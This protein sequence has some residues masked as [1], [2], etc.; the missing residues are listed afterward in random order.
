MT[1][2]LA[3][4]PG[5][6][7]GPYEVTGPI[8]QGGMG[9]V[10]SARDT[11]L[12]R[13]V[14]LKV[15]PADQVADPERRRRFLQ[16]ARAASAL[17]HPNI[18]TL[19][20]IAHEAGVDFLV[21]EH[22]SGTPL[23]EVIRSGKLGVT[24]TIDYATQIASA[25][26]AAHSAGILH[27]DIKPANLIVTS[28][29]RVKVL[30]FGLAK[31]AERP[32]PDGETRTA[33]RALTRPGM[34]MGTVAYMSPEQ[35]RGEPLDGRTDLFS[36]GVVLYE[37]ATGRPAFAKTLDWTRPSATGLPP[38]LQP[39]VFKL[40]EQ[41]VDLRYQTAADVAA[42]LK[43]LQRV[44]HGPE[45]SRR[46]W[47]RV[48]AAAAILAGI[49][50][51]ATWL[52]PDRRPPGRDEWVQLTNFPDSVSQP[53]ISPDGRMLTFIRGPG[54]FQT[55]GQVYVK[56]LPEGEPKQLT[57]DD[58]RKMSPVFSPDG[59]QIAYTTIN[60]QFAWDT[61]LV[62]VLG[63]EP[64][65]WLPNASGLVWVDRQQLLFSEIKAGQ[66]MAIVT[67]E[68][69]RAGARDVYIPAHERGMGHRS[70]S[71]PDRAWVVIVEM[72]G[73]GGWAPC[74]LVPLDGSSPGRQVGPPGGG[75]TFA[76]WSPD[77]ASIYLSSSAG[78]AFHLWRQPF[79]DGA[80]E[81]ITS[82]PTEEEGVALAPDGRSLVTAV[83]LRQRSIMLHAESAE[84]QISLEGYAFNPKFTPDG[85]RLFYQV[86]KSASALP[87]SS[88]LWMADVDSGRSEHF[89]S[90]VASAG[91]SGGVGTGSYSI[92]RDGRRVVLTMADATGKFRL[93]LVTIDRSAPPRQIPNVEGYQP[94]FGPPGEIVFRANE[95]NRRVLYRVQEDGR[96]LRKAIE[97]P[98]DPLGISLDGQSLVATG[99]HQAA[100]VY[101]LDGG[102][103]IRVWSR[104]ARLRWSSD[105]RSLFLSLSST[106]GTLYGSGRT[107]V[108]PL[109][110]GRLLPDI[111]SGGF[112]TEAELAAL[113]GVQIVEAA[114]VAPGPNASVYAFSRETTQRNLYRIPLSQ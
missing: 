24:Q 103:P 73:T 7:L 52:R 22:V 79:P 33:E 109:E 17:N 86:V 93:W 87:G 72:D 99:D 85:K 107:Y 12:Q 78:G 84:R 77:G 67:A 114:D 10:Y 58:L 31:L 28:D 23:D 83:G 56:L 30:D 111:P 35:A 21:M 25:L 15:L 54:T 94:V 34:V 9:E 57:H 48:A 39:I 51:A 46:R 59:S 80:P 90:N 44:A 3:L 96:G 37:M 49:A 106:G 110:P 41:E 26:A 97:E 69:T 32:D 50:V 102:A 36:L 19:H 63:G 65:R 105:G 55:E 13:T 89:F 113:P 64:S 75:C 61:W 71:S 8:G 45:T 43:R 66:H 6:R 91:T 62:P 100:T 4:T 1:R 18:M 40:L 82:G 108:L 47:L 104:D 53:A 95:E 74:R 101:P 11:R 38:D 81:Q 88:E 2:D 14:A 20:D 68:P 29:G 70:Y 76:G 42:D 92:S 60:R 27:R 98:G 5:T 112:Q 16:E